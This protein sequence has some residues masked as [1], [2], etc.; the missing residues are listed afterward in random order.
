LRDHAIAYGA[1]L[2]R[3]VCEV[4]GPLSFLEDLRQ[5]LTHAGVIAAVRRHDTAAIF[6]WLVTQLSLQGVSNGVA[7]AYM[8]RGRTGGR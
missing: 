3:R 2:V 7:V 1:D 8:T 5:E 4:A 6:A